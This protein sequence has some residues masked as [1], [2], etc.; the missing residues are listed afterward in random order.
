MMV[1]PEGPLH[2]P[3]FV[4]RPGHDSDRIRR[5][6]PFKVSGHIYPLQAQNVLVA[7]LIFDGHKGL[8]PF[9]MRSPLIGITD[10]AQGVIVI[11]LQK[12]QTFRLQA[13][14]MKIGR[15]SCREEC[16]YRWEAEK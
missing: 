14:Y 7:Q 4:S 1:G 8:L 5:H 16:R 15:A 6:H 10:I 2:K 13:R 12:T 3:S 11:L 9:G